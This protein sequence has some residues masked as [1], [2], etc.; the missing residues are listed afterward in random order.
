MIILFT[1]IF[2]I[3]VISAGYSIINNSSQDIDSTL[4]ENS[5][6]VNLSSIDSFN[7]STSLNDGMQVKPAYK[8]SNQHLSIVDVYDEDISDGSSNNSKESYPIKSSDNGNDSRIL[9][10]MD[11]NDDSHRA[12]MNYGSS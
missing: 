4:K 2:L 10:I 11:V 3:L 8:E 12:P 6:S 5:S 9:V 7:C 1:L